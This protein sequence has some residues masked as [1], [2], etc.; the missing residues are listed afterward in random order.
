MNYGTGITI[1]S[2]DASNPAV[3]TDFLVKNSSGI[4]FSDIAFEP[5][6]GGVGVYKLQTLNS[7]NI[8]FDHVTV[9]GPE[10]DAG[11]NINPFMI[12]NSTGVTVSNSE[13]S[14]LQNGINMLNNSDV[15]ITNNYFHDLRTDG[16]RG[17]GN[18]DLT[19]TNN[20]FTD[21][22]PADGDHPDAVQLWTTNTTTSASNITITDNVVIRGEGEAIQ[23]IFISDQVGT[24]PYQN[25]TVSDNVVIGGLPN[26]ILLQNVDGG[27]V[28]NNVVAALG[29]DKSWISVKD[30]SDV[31]IDGNSAT[32]YSFTGNESSVKLSDNTTLDTVLDGGVNLVTTKA[33][34]ISELVSDYL[35][36]E[37]IIERTT[38]VHA[39][40]L[41]AA[42][43]I[44]YINGTSGAD[45]LTVTNLGD[46]QLN[47]GD[48]NDYL[49]GGLFNNTL[50]GVKM[51]AWDSELWNVADWSR[52]KF[53]MDPDMSRAVREAF[54]RL[55]EEGLIYR[56]NRM[57]NWCTAC[58]T[59]LS[60]LE[61]EREEPEAGKA[62]AELFAFAYP[63]VEPT[64]G[65][66]EIGGT[67]P[68]N[69]DGG[70]IANGEPI[71]ASGLRQIH[72]IVR[73]LRGQA[74]DRQVPGNPRV[75]FTQLYGAPGTAGAAVL[76]R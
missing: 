74:G 19:V 16:V 13:F 17:G 43:S 64:D 33:Q 71:G 46:T 14:Q 54:V 67:M 34:W 3:I 60:D 62:N 29:S 18:S 68:I 26:G 50:V 22:H 20:Y 9:T 38:A 28:E 25:V 31:V 76:T 6:T 44:T 4:T 1:T 58:R 42:P 2:A 21:F 66:T 52:A 7:S 32:Q 69:T 65:V 70:L 11:L 10:G 5:D 59:V 15:T 51:N 56:A 37:G 12:R 55:Y 40:T 24:L 36:A 63:L 47:G 35:T 53:T 73:Q 30:S 49:T 45:R 41:A 72:E 61:V 75:G 57:V 48:G 39:A 23:G 27:V 8:T